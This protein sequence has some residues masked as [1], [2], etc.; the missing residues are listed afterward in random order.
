M[1][2]QLFGYK[3]FL[4]F[5]KVQLNNVTLG[6]EKLKIFLDLKYDNGRFV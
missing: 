1:K 2:I 3:V 5:V 4:N 6:F